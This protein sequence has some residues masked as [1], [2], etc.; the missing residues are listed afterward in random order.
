[1]SEKTMKGFIVVNIGCIECGVSS[2]VVGIYETKEDA[3]AV[4]KT[5][6]DKLSWREGGQNH[7][8]VFDLSVPQD[9]EYAEVLKAT[10]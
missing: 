7:F 10:P 3:D 6:E 2:G 5:C 8:D 9:S 4:A 1:M